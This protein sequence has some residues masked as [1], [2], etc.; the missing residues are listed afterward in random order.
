MTSFPPG[1]VRLIGGLPSCE[2]PGGEPRRRQRVRARS[3][4]ARTRRAAAGVGGAARRLR[5]ARLPGRLAVA[6][7]GRRAAAVEGRCCG[8]CS[9]CSRP[10]PWSPA[11][12]CPSARRAYAMIAAALA[13]LLAA[14]L[15]AGPRPRAAAAAPARRARLRA[16]QRLAGAEHGPA[17][18]RGRRPVAGAGAAAARL[19][20]GDA[21]RVCSR[22]G[23]ARTASRGYPFLSL[24]GAAR[25]DR[26]ARGVDGRR[27]GR[28][29]SARR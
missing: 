23:R 12:G 15:A 19:L 20:A 29:C 13:G 26:L 8:S 6:A 7:D 16:G 28:C 11:S 3:A 1:A 14:Y 9:R 10:A 22:S 27:R 5:G 24:A 18:L 4:G 21:R 25:A 2:N 17:P